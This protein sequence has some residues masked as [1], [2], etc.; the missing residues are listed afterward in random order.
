MTVDFKN[1]SDASNHVVLQRKLLDKYIQKKPKMFLQ[2]DH[3]GDEER[4]DPRTWELMDGSPLRILFN[5]KI[6]DP[7]KLSMMLRDIADNLSAPEHQEKWSLQ[8]AWLRDPENARYE[9]EEVRSDEVDDLP[10]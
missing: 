9:L 3:F 7:I 5:G 4:I 1:M 6:S 10:F 8:L 2:Y